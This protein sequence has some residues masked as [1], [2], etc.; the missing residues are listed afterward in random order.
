MF[1]FVFEH[2]SSK[3]TCFDSINGAGHSAAGPG[4]RPLTSIRTARTLQLKAVW[5]IIQNSLQ[6]AG[7]SSKKVSP[8]RDAVY[9]LLLKATLRKQQAQ[10]MR[11]FRLPRGPLRWPSRV[12]RPAD[13]NNAET[14]MCLY[15]YMRIYPAAPRAMAVSDPSL[16]LLKEFS[17]APLTPPLGP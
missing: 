5:G 14:H 4:D 1:S 9:I 6:E 13:K 16:S 12:T 2:Q 17:P 15:T 7:I 10:K 3:S 11:K 8:R